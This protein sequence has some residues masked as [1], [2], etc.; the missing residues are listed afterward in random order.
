VSVSELSDPEDIKLLHQISLKV[1]TAH[2]ESL[3][4]A[5]DYGLALVSSSTLHIS[6][7]GEGKLC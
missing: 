3:H 7:V 5:V 4:L 6:A 2:S 1:T